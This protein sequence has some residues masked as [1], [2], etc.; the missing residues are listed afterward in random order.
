MVLVVHV[1]L[2]TS[3]FFL[4]RSLVLD[5]RFVTAWTVWTAWTLHVKRAFLTS[6]CVDHCVDH[7]WTTDP[8]TA[9]FR[10]RGST[11]PALD[12]PRAVE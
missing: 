8:F 7:A 10:S 11:T 4:P 5:L 2:V 9:L 12:V 1:V 3:V 6:L